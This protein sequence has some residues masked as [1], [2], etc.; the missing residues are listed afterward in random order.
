MSCH[1]TTLFF[2]Q[3][4]GGTNVAA[5]VGLPVRADP[6]G[7]KKMADRCAPVELEPRIAP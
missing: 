6:D 2:R 1:N 5:V 7:S 3:E 4:G